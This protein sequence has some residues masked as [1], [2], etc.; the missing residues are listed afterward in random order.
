M[1]CPGGQRI[2]FDM[3]GDAFCCAETHPT[4]ERRF[5]C[6]SLIQKHQ[7]EFA[8]INTMIAFL[9]FQEKSHTAGRDK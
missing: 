9:G 5:T 6:K 3:V 7:G 8:N 1:C 4:L 2:I